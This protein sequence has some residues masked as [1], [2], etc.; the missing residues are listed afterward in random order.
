MAPLEAEEMPLL[1]LDTVKEHHLLD[2]RK[3]NRVEPR[4]QNSRPVIGREFFYLPPPALR[5]PSPK[6]D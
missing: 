5:A 4:E 2:Q 6:C 3:A 1:G